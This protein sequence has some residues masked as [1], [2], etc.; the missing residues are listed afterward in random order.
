M[1]GRAGGKR[2]IALL[3]SLAILD[4]HSIF[5][6]GLAARGHKLTYT[7]ATSPR[8][9]LFEYGQPLYDNV[10]YFAPT[11]T[12]FTA[13]GLEGSQTLADFVAQGGNLIMAADVDMSDL[14]R[15]MASEFG[16]D[17]DKKRTVVMDHFS[18]APALDLKGMHTNVVSSNLIENEKILGPVAGRKGGAAPVVFRGVGH[19]VDPENI[20][21]VPILSGMSST[22]SAAPLKE[23]PAPSL[24]SARLTNA[25]TTLG[26]ISG[27][28]GRNN[29]R[30]TISGSLDF[31]S[32]AYFQHTLDTTGQLA[33]NELV[34]LEISKWAFGE[35]GILRASN[36]THHRADGSNPEHLLATKEKP[37]LPFSL[38]PDPELNRQSLVYRIKDDIIYS[39]V[40]EEYDADRGGWVPYQASDVQLEFVMLDPHIRTFLECV[41]ETGRFWKLFKVPDNYGIF[42]FRILYRRPGLSVLAVN[43]QVSVRPFNHD[44]YERFIFSAFPYY[45]SAFSM[46]TGFLVFGVALLYSKP[47]KGDREGKNLKKE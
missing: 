11:T 39:L 47:Q 40:I 21:A 24:A 8:V 20:L 1:T 16:V 18:H 45:A 28:Q 29:A 3:D 33:G 42:K 26:L 5:F 12:A 32:D 17:F 23:I 31:F 46:M 4:T 44:E 41:P 27:V 7:L 15:E 36:V 35:R 19:I 43:T 2:T 37:D 6:A 30:A 13:P 10:V 25:G 9:T 38:F 14:T 22:Y 34:A